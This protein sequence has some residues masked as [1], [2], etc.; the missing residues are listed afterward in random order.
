MNIKRSFCVC[1]FFW[2][3]NSVFFFIE[4][5]FGK[6]LHNPHLMLQLDDRTHRA[7]G[8]LHQLLGEETLAY[9]TWRSNLLQGC[10]L[11]QRWN[12]FCSIRFFLCFNFFFVL[13]CTVRSM[14]VEADSLKFLFFVSGLLL[15]QW[16]NSENRKECPGNSAISDFLL[17]FFLVNVNFFYIMSLNN[18]G[19][20]KKI[21]KEHWKVV[22]CGFF[23]YD[24]YLYRRKQQFFDY[25]RWRRFVTRCHWS[26][27]I[28]SRLISFST[29]D[30]RK[31]ENF[32]ALGEV[33]IG[34]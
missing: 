32:I 17:R 4:S 8:F 18:P 14:L 12:N 29:P 21:P 22:C 11:L 26:F 31:S 28:F 7:A 33:P 3:R 1:L 23:S 24:I 5:G 30:Y 20:V 15:F 27:K 9:Q 25:I 10:L 19:A 6:P 2:K 34:E 13:S 16:Q